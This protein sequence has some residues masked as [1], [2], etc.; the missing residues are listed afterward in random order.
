MKKLRVLWSE[1]AEN[2]L[3]G[4]L[5]YIALDNPIQALKKLKEFKKKAD[6]LYIFPEKGR[7]VPEL[8]GFGILTY[9]ELIVPP[10]RIIYRI[11]KKT[12][13]VLSVLDSRR[14]IEDLLLSR[15]TRQ[16]I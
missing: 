4:I 3:K 13:Y 16:T 6:D 5:A 9:R 8:M 11:T 14:N 2:D 7:V 12:I 1:A 15:L 10:W